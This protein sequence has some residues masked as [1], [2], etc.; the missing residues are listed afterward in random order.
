MEIF[1][2]IAAVVVAWALAVLVIIRFMM[3]AQKNRRAQRM[4]EAE[5][6]RRREAKRRTIEDAA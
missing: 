2:I 1:L 5:H 3:G 4:A 6:E